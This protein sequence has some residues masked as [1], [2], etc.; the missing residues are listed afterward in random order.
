[1]KQK[2]K[3]LDL[4]STKVVNNIL[5]VYNKSSNEFISN[6]WYLEANRFA[7]GLADKHKVDLSVV[8]GVIAALSPIKR[9]DENKALAIAVMSGSYRGHIKAFL[10]KAKKIKKS[11]GDVLE[12]SEILNGNK[13]TSFYLNILNPNQT[14]AVTIDR[15]ALAIC[16]GRN[17]E[18]K[19]GVG[20]TL[21][22]YKFFVECYKLAGAKMGISP[23]KMQSITWQQ[24]RSEKG[25]SDD[26]SYSEDVPF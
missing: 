6:H 11:S 14:E 22:Q 19:E 9:W 21:R 24:W 4:T 7:Q 3:G 5:R 25:I 23:V 10:D 8:C 15:H 18:E 17:I 1:M 2:F 26:S 16:L 12:V 20:V 13:I